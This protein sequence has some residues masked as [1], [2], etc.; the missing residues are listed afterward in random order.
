M[1]DRK[2][3][4]KDYSKTFNNVYPL[5]DKLK[6]CLFIYDHEFEKEFRRMMD[7]KVNFSL[8]IELELWL[9]ILRGERR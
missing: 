1:E 8:G 5:N 7:E 4:P 3:D 9:V 6:G 2:I